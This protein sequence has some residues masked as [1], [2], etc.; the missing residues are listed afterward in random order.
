MT[1]SSSLRGTYDSPCNLPCSVSNPLKRCFMSAMASDC[2][3]LDSSKGM[4]AVERL[5]Y[6]T[7]LYDVDGV[8]RQ[9][10]TVDELGAIRR[11]CWSVLGLCARVSFI[12]DPFLGF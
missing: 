5:L 12:N 10:R 9:R 11:S 7:N 8:S 2:E 6:R 4:V 3:R 1:I